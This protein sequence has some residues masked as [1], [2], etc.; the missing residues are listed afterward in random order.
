MVSYRR[1]RRSGGPL[2]R[3]VGVALSLLLILGMSARGHV[4]QT[5]G[6]AFG[7]EHPAEV[8]DGHGDHG[9]TDDDRCPPNCHRCPCGQMPMTSSAPEMMPF[10]WL[11]PHELP[12]LTPPAS[13][14]RSALHRLDR[15][16]RIPC[17]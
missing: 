8:S 4:Y 7:C 13:I 2:L 12:E 14:G 9:S 10:A 6:L 3:W 15:P 11:E 16:P 5:F 17:G 1:S